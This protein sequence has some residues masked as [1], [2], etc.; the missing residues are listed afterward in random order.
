VAWTLDLDRCSFLRP[1]ETG[2]GDDG[3]L[4]SDLRCWAQAS[5]RW[6]SATEQRER[7]LTSDHARCPILLAAL[8]RQPSETWAQAETAA[9]AVAESCHLGEARLEVQVQRLVEL[10]QVFDGAEA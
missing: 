6:I 9:Q 3:T 7:C 4:G 2:S 5:A 10:G 1:I 8:A